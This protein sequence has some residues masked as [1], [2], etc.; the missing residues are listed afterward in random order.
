MYGTPASPFLIILERRPT[1]QPVLMTAQT[2][3][4][5]YPTVS[6]SLRS[7]ASPWLCVRSPLLIERHQVNVAKYYLPP[8]L[9]VLIP[10]HTYVLCTLYMWWPCYG[11]QPQHPHVAPGRGSHLASHVALLFDFLLVADCALLKLRF[12]DGLDG[13]V[14]DDVGELPGLGVEHSLVLVQGQLDLRSTIMIV[15][16]IKSGRKTKRGRGKGVAERV[17]WIC[18]TSSSPSPSNMA[19][20]KREEGGK[21]R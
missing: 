13:H 18:S 3:L 16:I 17:S 11:R 19:A 12:V 20:R 9:A 5:Q 15:I 14:S 10:L 4:Q 2:R 1:Q 7:C 6:L 8:V 21:G